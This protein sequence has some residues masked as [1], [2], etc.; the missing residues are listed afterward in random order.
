M[1]DYLHWEVFYELCKVSLDVSHRDVEGL[2]ELLE[3]V[4]GLQLFRGEEVLELGHLLEGIRAD[5][6]T[7]LGHAHR[8]AIW[9]HQTILAKVWTKKFAFLR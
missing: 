3:P 7:L 9:Q 1:R 8:L 2:L 5:G 6:L 4:T